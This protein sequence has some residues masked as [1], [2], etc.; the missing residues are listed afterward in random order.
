MV[1]VSAAILSNSSLKLVVNLFVCVV[2]ISEIACGSQN[3]G[4]IRRG[5]LGNLTYIYELR[6]SREPTKLGQLLVLYQ[7]RKFLPP[8]TA[9]SPPGRRRDLTLVSPPEGIRASP[10][11]EILVL[12]HLNPLACTCTP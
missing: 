9:I 10:P 11:G 1:L 4:W 6:R 5:R 7:N 2:L 3:V 8:E 12:L